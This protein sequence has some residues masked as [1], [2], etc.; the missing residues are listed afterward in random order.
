LSSRKSCR[1][2]WAAQRAGRRARSR[3]IAG[4][5]SAMPRSMQHNLQ[6]VGVP[7]F[8]S[9]C[10]WG[11]MKRR[12][13][14]SLSRGPFWCR[15]IADEKNVQRL[16]R[17]GRIAGCWRH[18]SR[19]RAGESRRP[20]SAGR[21]SGSTSVPCPIGRSDR[22]RKA[23]IAAQDGVLAWYWRLATDRETFVHRDQAKDRLLSPRGSPRPEDGDWLSIANTHAL[24]ARRALRMCAGQ[25]FDAGPSYWAENPPKIVA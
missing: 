5:N 20:I 15:I 2:N 25:E 9:R 13:M 14:D 12:N 22:A 7:R 19:R 21:T 17:R 18:S 23:T 24:H 4:I 6:A 16:W 3:F 8:T 10:R 11:R 1:G